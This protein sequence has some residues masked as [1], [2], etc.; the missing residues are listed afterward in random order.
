MLFVT[1]DTHGD[2]RRF[3]STRFPLGRELT[4]NDYV[5]ILGDFGGVW[6]YRGENKHETYWLNWLNDKSWTTCFVDGN[7]ENFSRLNALPVEEWNGG[8]VHKVRDSVIHLMR[9][10]VFNIENKKFFTFGGAS[11]HDIH[12]GILDPDAPDFKK[13]YREYR[14][15]HKQFRVKNRGWWSEENPSEEEFLNACYNLDQ[16]DWKVDY[17]LA[18]T[19]P[20]FIQSHLYGYYVTDETSRFLTNFVQTGLDFE[21]FYAGHHHINHTV[22]LKYNLLYEKIEEIGVPH[23][24]FDFKK[25]K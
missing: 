18:H 8:K 15:E 11:S 3:N 1:G 5:F 25:K 22:F 23:F 6:D 21:K 10:E 16:N 4:K 19:V 24:K 17:V 12:D 13:I 2:F 7:H 14:R 9:G 20:D